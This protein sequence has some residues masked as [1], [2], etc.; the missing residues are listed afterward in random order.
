MKRFNLKKFFRPL[1]AWR[2]RDR[3]KQTND[4]FADWQKMLMATFVGIIFLFVSHYLL[5]RRLVPRIR[6]GGEAVATKSAAVA[7]VLDEKMLGQ[8]TMDINDRA[9]RFQDLSTNAIQTVD[10]SR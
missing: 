4:P 3:L 6:P 5:Y 2:D 9:A 10:P 1:F 7:I 8:V